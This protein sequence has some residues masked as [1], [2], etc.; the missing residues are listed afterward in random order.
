[1]KYYCKQCNYETYDSGNIIHHKNTKKHK[2]NDINSKNN[3]NCNSNVIPNDYKTTGILNKKKYVCDKC[4][5]SFAY[6]QGLYKHLS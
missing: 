4:N 5:K 3:Y 6:R 2:Q 1:M